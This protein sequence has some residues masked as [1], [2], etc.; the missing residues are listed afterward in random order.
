MD[1][2]TILDR[3][4]S[5]GVAVSVLGDKLRLVP[6]S[7]VPPDLAGAVREAKGE[8]LAYLID[9]SHVPVM[10]DT[11]RL[12]AWASELAEQEIV[13]A[14][15]VSFI[16]TSLR[17]II[18]ERISEKA[19]HYLRVIHYARLQRRTGGMGRFLPPWWR[20]REEEAIGALAA[21]REAVEVSDFSAQLGDE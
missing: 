13:L 14:E 12:L 21:L 11:S 3:L 1:P 9:E 15:P 17:T 18:T 7:M 8:V 2:A 5:L 4:H 10:V 20:E 16:E 19:T 6:G